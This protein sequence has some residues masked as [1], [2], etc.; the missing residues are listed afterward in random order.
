MLPASRLS[1]SLISTDPTIKP[2]Q[3]V[4]EPP[5]PSRV[6]VSALQSLGKNKRKTFDLREE[7]QIGQSA[8][9][10]IVQ[11]APRRM[12]VA[13][14]PAGSASISSTKSK[15][16]PVIVQPEIIP[17]AIDSPVQIAE[18]LRESAGLNP[19]QMG[20]MIAGLDHSPGGAVLTTENSYALLTQILE[21]DDVCSEAQKDAMLVGLGIA[22]DGQNM[23]EA[24]RNA[25]TKKILHTQD[26]GMEDRMGDMVRGLGVILGGRAMSAKNRDALMTQI[27]GAHA[28]CGMLQVLEML[29]GLGSAL[30]GQTMTA[31][32][33]SA[34]MAQ[35][36][37]SQESH[38][39]TR[40]GQLLRLGVTPG[41]KG[42]RNVSISHAT[43][44]AV[45][46]G[47][48][49]LRLG[50]TLGHRTMTAE[51]RNALMTQALSG[52]ATYSP[53][54]MGQAIRGMGT[55]LGAQAMTAQN[56]SAL[57]TQ[58]LGAHATCSEAQMAEMIKQSG[59]VL[60]G[61]LMTTAN[62]N[63]LMKQILLSHASCGMPLV[64][65]MLSAFGAALGA[66]NMTAGHLRALVR[67]ILDGHATY[68]AQQ[69]GQMIW[70]LAKGLG[71][72][73]MTPERCNAL[74]I[75]I[76]G[77]HAAC[78]NE[79]IR[80]M[81]AGLARAMGA[82]ALGVLR[83][84]TRSA[85]NRS[86]L[87]TCILGNH[88]TCSPAQIRWMIVF[89]C[90]LTVPDRLLA[91][92]VRSAASPLK[93]SMMIAAVIAGNDSGV[94]HRQKCRR[95]LNEIYLPPALN[96]FVDAACFAACGDLGGILTK[97][98]LAEGDKLNLIEYACGSLMPSDQAAL[99]MQL[100]NIMFLDLPGTLKARTLSILL[101]KGPA[102]PA[103]F[104]IVRQWLIGTLADI[105][106][107]TWI[108]TEQTVEIEG[109]ST[110]FAEWCVDMT[111]LYQGFKEHMTLEFIKKER[112]MIRAH[113]LLPSIVRAKILALLSAREQEFASL[114]ERA[115][116]DAWLV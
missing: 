46:I 112:E 72:E 70:G 115:E 19:A 98:G 86:A 73:A 74:M 32:S 39:E 43:Y 79:Q 75:R 51:H 55:A 20:E 110:A 4:A 48:M 23:T 35:I 116:E 5:L 113:P 62:C 15:T 60:G 40:I 68:S 76:S 30:G 14:R 66:R 114:S 101:S 64:S 21:A 56:R 22:L 18:I 61:K 7:D 103:C 93:K 36:L 47:E 10:R 58:I 37:S 97:D 53:Q 6:T 78:S 59:M 34:L 111:A 107:S 17:R 33:C 2:A 106:R 99:R 16:T 50:I 77:V 49:V 90:L 26:P 108:R 9:R 92:I 87:M 12:Q 28:M 67:Q 24:K 42:N 104:T 96:S 1:P 95:I 3:K 29:E 71:G 8:T 82:D 25:L 57:M 54:L 65:R 89:L 81:L 109:R 13:R 91:A 84:R 105:P 38:S 63:A 88:A 83:G 45:Q 85:P 41:A 69:M 80:A 31:E 27:L 100:E 102:N 11:S 52:Y 94:D 44:S